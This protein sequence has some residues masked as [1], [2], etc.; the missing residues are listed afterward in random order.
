MSSINNQPKEEKEY[1]F[2]YPKYIYIKGHDLNFKSPILKNNT[3]RYRCK[4]HQ[5]KYFIKNKEENLHKILNNE[6]EVNYIECNEHENHKEAMKVKISSDNIVTEEEINKL[7]YQLILNNIN[8]PLSFHLDNLKNNKI[9]W[10]KNKIRNLLY[11]IRESKFPK[12]YV[13]FLQ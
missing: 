11:N 9:N 7:A 2:N 1:Q 10:K 6:K 12:D 8:Q 4:N 3:Y 13:F 5:C